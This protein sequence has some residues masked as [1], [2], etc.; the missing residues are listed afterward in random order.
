[1]N[2]PAGIRMRGR[3]P[4]I[5]TQTHIPP[6]DSPGLGPERVRSLAF[7][8][9]KQAKTSAEKKQLYEK[10]LFGIEKKP[11]PYLLGMMNLILHEIE[12]PNI[13]KRNT[14]AYPF[15][16]ITD[17]ERFDCIMT[18]PPFGGQEENT[19]PKICLKKC[20]QLILHWHFCYS[21]WSH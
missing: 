20:R 16:E 21:S 14:L 1:M 10:T 18:N 13:Q 9:G 19:I 2:P 5:I 11:L 3:V 17:K 12:D 15:S 4:P 6:Q 7:G 8:K